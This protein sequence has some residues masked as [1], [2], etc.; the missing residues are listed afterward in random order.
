MK[1]LREKQARDSDPSIYSDI[2]V[3][4]S[5]SLFLCIYNKAHYECVCDNL[6]GARA[7]LNWLTWCGSVPLDLELEK[8]PLIEQKGWEV[9]VLCSGYESKALAAMLSVPF[10]DLGGADSNS[11]Y[12]LA[13]REKITKAI[14][15][16][17]ISIGEGN[18]TV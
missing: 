1:A 15:L 17:S 11:A 7:L 8:Y 18:G 9:P 3:S 2:K 14:Y 6:K 13:Q 12:V 5:L 16:I 10:N 4:S